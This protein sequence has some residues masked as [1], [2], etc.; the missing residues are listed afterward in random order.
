[1]TVYCK[2]AVSCS[3]FITHLWLSHPIWWVLKSKHIPG[4]K[5]KLASANQA[6][7][8]LLRTSLQ[9][10]RDLQ[11]SFAWVCSSLGPVTGPAYASRRLSLWFLIQLLRMPSS[12]TPER[13]TLQSK[14]ESRSLVQPFALS[15]GGFVGSSGG[16]CCKIQVNHGVE[17]VIKSKRQRRMKGKCH[18]TC[19]VA[20]VSWFQ[21]I[22]CLLY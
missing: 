13:T 5:L 22:T 15:L 1:M 3:I 18:R 14:Q 7:H 12:C 8:F 6:V 17:V 19:E 16:I 20:G 9:E 4:C 10:L 11:L 2:Q 21:I